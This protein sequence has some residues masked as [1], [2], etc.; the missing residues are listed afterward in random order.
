[1]GVES[2][3]IKDKI[4][5]Y[6]ERPICE[7]GCGSETII[8]GV[9]GIDGRDF[10]CVSFLTDNLYSLPNQLEDKIG[11]FTTVFSSHTLE[12]LPDAY[13]CVEEWGMLCKK[14]GYFILYLPDGDYYNNYENEEHFHDTKYETFL[15]WFKRAFCGDAKNFKGEQ[16]ASPMFELIESG[17]D[18]TEKNHYSFY[19]VALKL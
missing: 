3:K 8:D 13:R 5:Q 2:H 1:M 12:H 11:Y 19:I 17:Q 10:P 7:I 9:F 16:Y 15:M 4:S 6:L 18:V 14:G